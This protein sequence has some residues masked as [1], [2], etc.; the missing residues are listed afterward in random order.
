[1]NA[2][3]GDGLKF[4]NNNFSGHPF[5]SRKVMRVKVHVAPELG[6]RRLLLPL[7]AQV[8]SLLPHLQAAGVHG[9]LL[10]EVEGY[11]V[12][13]DSPSSVLDKNDVVV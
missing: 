10:L 12:L 7:G 9:D 1:M 5:R 2:G 3:Y 6:E 11:E 4:K 8:G 13:P